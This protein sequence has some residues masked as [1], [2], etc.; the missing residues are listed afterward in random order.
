MFVPIETIRLT[1]A[2]GTGWMRTINEIVA[3]T[4]AK[5]GIG[6]QE[7]AET[8][9][10]TALVDQTGTLHMRLAVPGGEWATA[11]VPWPEWFTEGRVQ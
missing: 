2:A 4:A 8:S 10:W 5:L 1:P 3:R 6:E 11:D 7:V 9:A